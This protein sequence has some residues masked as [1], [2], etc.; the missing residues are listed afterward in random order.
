MRAHEHDGDFDVM[1]KGNYPLTAPVMSSMGMP[2]LLAV[3]GVVGV[4]G[5][6]KDAKPVPVKNGS[7]LVPAKGFTSVCV[8]SRF[9]MDNSGGT[10]NASRLL[11]CGVNAKAVTDGMGRLET[12]VVAATR[13]GTTGAGVTAAAEIRS[14][15]AI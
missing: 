10:G 13:T 9:E 8:M 7:K 12:G 4:V 15:A 2:P 3:V 1:P 14:G 11:V 5:V 6:M